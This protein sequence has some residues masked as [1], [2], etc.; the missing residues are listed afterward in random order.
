MSFV[1]CSFIL[2]FF[3]SEDGTNKLSGNIG[4]E[5]LLIAA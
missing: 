3:T 5:L 4:K 1:L 2:N